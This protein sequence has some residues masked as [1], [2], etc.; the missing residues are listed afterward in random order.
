MHGPK[1]ILDAFTAD[2]L[3]CNNLQ[4]VILYSD[5]ILLV[6][7]KWQQLSIRGRYQQT[8]GNHEVF[9]SIKRILKRKSLSGNKEEGTCSEPTEFWLTV[10]RTT[11]NWMAGGMKR[12]A[13][14]LAL[15]PAS[16]VSCSI[17]SQLSSVQSLCA[18]SYLGMEN[19]GGGGW[20]FR[21]A[22]RQHFVVRLLMQ[23]GSLSVSLSTI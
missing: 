15:Q 11:G 12:T 16:P 6:Q 22:S 23:S 20:T 3:F 7:P 18:T 13:H 17:G 1:E 14:S 9:R 5:S 8:Q 21:H 19:F 10:E 2:I 4:C